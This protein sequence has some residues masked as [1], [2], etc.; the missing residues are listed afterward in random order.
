MPTICSFTAF[1]VLTLKLAIALG[2]AGSGAVAGGPRAEGS[3]LPH[4]AG[5]RG[6]PLPAAV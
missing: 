6:A 3:R 5:L 2:T 1:V 4:A